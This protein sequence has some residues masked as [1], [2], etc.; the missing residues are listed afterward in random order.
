MQPIIHKPVWIVIV[1][2]I[3]AGL[4]CSISTS[5]AHFENP[6]MY[7]DADGTTRTTSYAP[8]DT[9]YCRVELKNAAGDIPTKAE[10]YAVS[11]EDKTVR[12]LITQAE[13]E[14][15]DGTLTFDLTP[16][17]EGWPVGSYQVVLYLNDKPKE[18][19]TF[20]VK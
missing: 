2:L 6:K 10:W 15:G 20:K 8:A 1:L 9:F 16:P 3:A 14:S 5:T 12:T 11:V 17:Q 7:K 19:L 18:T 4:A 13:M